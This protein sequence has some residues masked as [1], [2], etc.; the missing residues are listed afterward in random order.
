MSWSKPWNPNPNPKE[1]YLG[2]RNPK[3]LKLSNS[4]LMEFDPK[5][6]ED[7]TWVKLKGK[8]RKKHL[9]K[10]KRF[11][12]LAKVSPKNRAKGKRIPVQ[13]KRFSFDPGHDVG[14]DLD[15]V[16]NWIEEESE[17]E[18]DL[19][20]DPDFHNWKEGFGYEHTL[21]DRDLADVVRYRLAN[22][23]GP[24]ASSITYTRVKWFLNM[25]ERLG[26]VS[27]GESKVTCSEAIH[28]IDTFFDNMGTEEEFATLLLN[29]AKSSPTDSTIWMGFKMMWSD[30]IESTMEWWANRDGRRGEISL[31]KMTGH[32]HK[33]IFT[34]YPMQ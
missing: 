20:R 2:F 21:T 25:M 17:E 30:V 13:T 12:R 19:V 3:K 22:G 27:R 9:G 18:G 29:I 14:P 16:N 6:A 34:A 15:S 32:L 7:P 28:A 8:A 10:L 33:A 1:T 31:S 11:A 26:V 5:T 4:C 24:C 23:E